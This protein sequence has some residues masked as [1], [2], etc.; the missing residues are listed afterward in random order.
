MGIVRLPFRRP[1]GAL[2]ATL[3]MAGQPRDDEA[4]QLVETRGGITVAEVIP[5]TLEL[6][7]CSQGGK[8]EN[9]GFRG[10]GA[11]KAITLGT[12]CYLKPLVS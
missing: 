5:I 7:S 12:L 3:Q 6:R 1:E 8:A 2:A 10:S 9:K 4:V 11:P